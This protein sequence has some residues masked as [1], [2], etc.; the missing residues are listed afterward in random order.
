[1]KTLFLDCS[2]GVS[3][4]MLLAALVDAGAPF[5][6]LRSELQRIGLQGFELRLEERMVSGVRTGFVDVRQTSEQPLRHLRD[7][8]AMVEGKALSDP[9]RQGACAVFED[10]ARAEAK[11]H[12]VAV[13]RVHFH[14]IGAVDTV[15]DVV[16]ALVLVESLAPARVVCSAVNL[17]SGFVDMAHGRHPVPPPAVA[18]L[19]KGIPTFST[20]LG[21]EAATPTGMALVRRLADSFGR[22][23]AGVIARVGYGS[24]TRSCDERPTYV[25]AFVLEALESAA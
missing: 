9:V 11:V 10:L 3:G 12:Q 14:E 2:T 23:P 4:D 6:L 13:E 21:I 22:L 15:V 19:A 17:G 1:M 8:K 24:G 18:E 25:R 7:L 5:D 20:D 16:G